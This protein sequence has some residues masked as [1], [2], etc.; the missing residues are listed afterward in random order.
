MVLSVSLMVVGAFVAF[1]YRGWVDNR[2]IIDSRDLVLQSRAQV[3]ELKAQLADQT[4]QLA[5]LKAI[6]FPFTIPIETTTLSS[7]PAKS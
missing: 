4:T 2:D 7:N 5:A 6:A 3:R 1:I